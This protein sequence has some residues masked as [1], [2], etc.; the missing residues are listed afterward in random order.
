MDYKKELLTRLYLITFAIVIVALALVA[1][2]FQIGVMEG[3]RWRSYGDSLYVK[4]MPIQADRGDILAD[5]GSLLSTSVPFFDIHMDLKAPGLNDALFEQKVDSLA[6]G[7]SNYFFPT[8]TP[9]SIAGE[10]RRERKRNN[11]YYLIKKDATYGEVQLLKSFPLLRLNPNKGGFISERKTKRQKP[12]RQLASRTIGLDRDNSYSVGLESS[13]D[14]VLVGE[15]GRRLVRRLTRGVYIPVDDLARIEPKR[16]LDI[17]TTLNVEIQD[18]AQQALAQALIKHQAERGVAIVMEV[19]TGA[20]KAMVNLQQTRTGGYEEL[21]N[22]AVKRSTEPGSTF[23]LASVMAL[24]ESGL[25]RPDSKVNLNKGRWNFYDKTMFDSSPHDTEMATLEYAFVNSSNV[26]ISRLVDEKFG[27]SKKEGLFIDYMKKFQLNT[28]TGIELEGEPTPFIKEAN[29]KEDRWSGVS[30]P[31]MSVGYELTMTPLQILRF[32]NTVANDGRMMKP[33]LVQAIQNG[34]EVIEEIKPQVI[35]ERIASPQTIK[36]IQSMMVKVVEEGTAKA[37][38]SEN[39]AIG[40]KTGT[41]R[42]DYYTVSERKQYNASFSGFFPADNPEYSCIVVIYHPQTGGIYGGDVA[43][44]V[45]KAIADKCFALFGLGTSPVNVSPKPLLAA[46]QLPRY[47][48]GYTKEMTALCRFMKLDYDQRTNADFAIM[49][50]DEYQVR[51][52]GR[53]VDS[54]QVPNVMGMGLRDAVYAIERS[55]SKPRIYGEGRVMRQS[56]E[57]GSA[58][59]EGQTIDIKLE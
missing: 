44:P 1:K 49:I 16:G 9:K 3:E 56:P 38:R 22:D 53:K 11:R 10:L 6:L 41:A 17:R 18:F 46:H 14:S 25:A 42:T 51:I 50:P 31:W 43:A 37:I 15:T 55:G 7:L 35:E 30:L 54:D 20:I 36:T 2:T 19:K 58:S 59:R 23:K 4:Y 27:A 57:A 28:P 48:V 34:S 45:F 39:Y 8:K 33:Y 32:Y 5:N 13:F 26:G 21:D 52:E 47:E 24:L 40:G 29:S 12:L